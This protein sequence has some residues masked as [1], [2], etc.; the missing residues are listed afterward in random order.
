M[1]RITKFKYQKEAKAFKSCIV[2][3]LHI[4][5][6]KLNK[7]SLMNSKSI[8]VDFPIKIKGKTFNDC[9]SSCGKLIK[10]KYLL[11]VSTGYG[12][13]SAKKRIFLPVILCP[14]DCEIRDIDNTLNLIQMPV[15]TIDMN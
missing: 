14:K 13:F 12:S 5:A 10:S 4:S 15:T 11:E 9:G 6:D 1:H 2:S 7:Q 8:N 3:S